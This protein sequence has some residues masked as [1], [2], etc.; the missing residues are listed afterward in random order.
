MNWSQIVH[1][2]GE[3][4]GV[5][6]V[7]GVLTLFLSAYS[8]HVLTKARESLK[9]IR[10]YDSVTRKTMVDRCI[11]LLNVAEEVRAWVPVSRRQMGW[12]A[13]KDML[14]RDNEVKPLKCRVRST[15]ALKRGRTEFS[16]LVSSPGT[17]AHRTSRNILSG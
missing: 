1:W 5:V 4:A 11:G 8:A 6:S 7:A 16:M 17:P 9:R 12:Q 14:V 15:L 10:D 2:I 3:H 13:S